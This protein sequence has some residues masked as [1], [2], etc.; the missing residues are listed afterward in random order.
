MAPVKKIILSLS[1]L[2]KISKDLSPFPDCS[3]ER[4]RFFDPEE[5]QKF[6]L[7]DKVIT[8]RIEK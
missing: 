2:E 5:A 4:D 6:G 3:M 7:I 1:S 8:T